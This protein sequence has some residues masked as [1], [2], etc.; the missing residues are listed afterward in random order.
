VTEPPAYEL[1]DD[2]RSLGRPDAGALEQGIQLPTSPDYQIRCAAHSFGT[3][4]TIGEL[5]HTMALMRNRGY[6][7]ELVVGDLSREDGGQYGPHR[8]HQSGRDV[9]LWLPVRGGRYR[10][11]CDHC[12]TDMCRPEPEEV[13]WPATWRLIQALAGRD[14]VQD[15]FLDWSLHPA[16]RDAAA[17]LGTPVAEIDRQIQY[18]RRGHPTLVKHSDGHVHHLHVRFRE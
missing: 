6:E 3:S 2:T 5:M 7:G 15:I 17:E 18:P 1:P 11:G 4:A 16:L 8:S 13:D 10:R 9:D 12:G 14:A